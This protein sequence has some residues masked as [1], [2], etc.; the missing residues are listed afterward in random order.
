MR[1]DLSALSARDTGSRVRLREPEFD[2]LIVNLVSN[3]REA[4]PDG[5]RLDVA[6][7]CDRLDEQRAQHLH[8]RPGEYVAMRVADEG[9][10]IDAATRERLFEPFFTTRADDGG[11]GL[12]LSTVAAIVENANGAIEVA[13]ELGR[14]TVFTIWLPVMGQSADSAALDLDGERATVLLVEAQDALRG[15]AARVLRLHGYRVLTATDDE[16]A[17]EQA[18]HHTGSIDL[19]VV[20]PTAT[21][22]AALERELRISH[23]G[24][25]LLHTADLPGADS[26]GPP[27]GGGVGLAKPFTPRTLARAV[28]ATLDAAPAL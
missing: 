21:C 22:G 12:G 14:G 28:R 16:D 11:T 15:L 7:H 10:G 25:R 3:A 24:L 23:P 18:L 2:Q 19:L 20:D 6:L 1:Y 13:S 17:L 5:G 4:M 8:V 26:F 27:I 9:C